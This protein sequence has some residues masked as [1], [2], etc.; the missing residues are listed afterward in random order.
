MF[1]LFHF[2]EKIKR[3]N[4]TFKTTKNVGFFVIKEHALRKTD[5][6]VHCQCRPT[7]KLWIKLGLL[8][9]FGCLLLSGL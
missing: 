9:L 1:I 5:G 6:Q 7:P 3:Q 2:V 4:K 8:S